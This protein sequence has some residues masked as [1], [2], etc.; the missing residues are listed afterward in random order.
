MA[1][2]YSRLNNPS[3][4]IL[5]HRLCLWNGAEE[6]ASFA[7]DMAAISTTL[8]ALLQPGNGVLH[9]EPVYGGSDFFLKN[10]LHKFGIEAVNF[11]PT[12]TPAQLAARA[13]AIAPGRLAM[14]FVETPANPTNHLVDL[15]ACAALAR[16]YATADKPVR[17]VVDNAFLG[18][19]FQHPLKHGADVVLYSATKFLGGHSDLIAGAALAS[20]PVMK[21]IKA[22]RTFMGIMCNP[23]TG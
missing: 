19:V 13:A 1:L 10:V 14:I 15:E 6:A 16:Q 11:R 20:K 22:M 7:C 5:K 4:E 21:E 17:L 8:L 18:P 3:L 12:D 9:S 23:N 2:I